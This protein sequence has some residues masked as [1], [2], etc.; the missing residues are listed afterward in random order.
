MLTDDAFKVR[1]L[2]F[3]TF[4]FLAMDD[5]K[6]DLDFEEVATRSRK[7]GQKTGQGTGHSQ[8]ANQYSGKKLSGKRV[9]MWMEDESGNSAN[10]F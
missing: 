10:H 1:F 4:R 6:K 8:D 9:L 7:A 5:S 2:Q 3:S